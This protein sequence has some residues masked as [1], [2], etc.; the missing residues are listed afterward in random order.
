M[1]FSEKYF[2]M[3]EIKIYTKQTHAHIYDVHISC[4]RALFDTRFPKL[5]PSSQTLISCGVRRDGASD[6]GSF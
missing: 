6:A 4:V 1:N 3:H 5:K 2:F